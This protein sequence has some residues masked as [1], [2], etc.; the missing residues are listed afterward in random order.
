[1]SAFNSWVTLTRTALEETKPMLVQL[2]KLNDAC[3]TLASNE[4]T[5]TDLQ[6]CFIL[7]KVLPELYSTVALTILATRVPADLKP[8]MIQ[9]RILNEE[10]H[11]SGASALLNQV[12]P[13]KKT[14][15]ITCFY[16]KKP[17]HKSPEC[18]KKKWD[19]EQKAKGKGKATETQAVTL[20]KAIHAHIVPSTSTIAK[21]LDSNNEI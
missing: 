3:L 21:V 6:F 4:M 17:S 2:Q 18:W 14:S 16:C 20:N 12:A 8:Q 10:G 7:I 1:M 19:M 5:I 13:V 15:D 9:E 11:W